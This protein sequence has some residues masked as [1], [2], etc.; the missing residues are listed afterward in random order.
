MSGR[1]FNPRACQEH[2]AGICFVSSLRSYGSLFSRFYAQWQGNGGVES[3]LGRTWNGHTALISGSNGAI[4]TIVGWDP[5]SS[6]SA[7]KGS[8]GGRHNSMR[9]ID[10]RWRDDTGMNADPTAQYYGLKI[11]Q[12]QH[13]DFRDFLRQDL[14][15]TQGFGRHLNNTGI[16]FQYAFAPGKW[17]ERLSSLEGNNNGQLQI[18][19]NCSD[20]AF[21]VLASFLYDWRKGNYVTELASFMNTGDEKNKNMSQGRLM[22]WSS[23]MGQQ[24]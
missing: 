6:W 19:S 13:N 1:G 11:S 8:V 21:H 20:A 14:L 24:G 22:Q 23:Q 4:D 3:S 12:T 17:M 9:P 7:F 15:G 5:N 10:G 18:I 16:T 2:F